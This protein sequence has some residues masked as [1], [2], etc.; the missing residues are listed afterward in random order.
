M[1]GGGKDRE[2]KR[3]VERARTESLRDVWRGQ[4]QRVWERCVE[5]AR[6]ESLRDVWRGQGQR[7]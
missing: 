1:C 7:A 4:G 5:G 3:S 6:T 2:P